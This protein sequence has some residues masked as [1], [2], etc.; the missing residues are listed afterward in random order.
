VENT[1]TELFGENFSLYDWRKELRTLKR[2]KLTFDQIQF[3]YGE[4]RKC[5]KMDENFRF[6][7]GRIEPEI[8][9]LQDFSDSMGI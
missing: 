9:T 3:E 6:E 1:A 4:N 5:P 2:V 7:T 8:Q